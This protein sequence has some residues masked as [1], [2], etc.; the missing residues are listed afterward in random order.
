MYYAN[1]AAEK[2]LGKLELRNQ[3]ARKAYE[4]QEIANAALTVKSTIPFNMFKDPILLDALGLKD[5]YLEADLERAI[6]AGLESFILEFGHGMSFVAR[7]KRMTMDGADHYLDLLFYHRDLKRLV[8]V[9]LKIGAFIPRDEGQ[10]RFYLKWLNRY[11][12]REGENEPIGLILCTRADR[13]QVELMDLDSSGIAVAEY[14]TNLP[15][16]A[17]LEEKIRAILHEARERL[18]RR[19][20]LPAG[21]SQKQI[22][23]FYETDE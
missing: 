14:W 5:N 23:W 1:D 15:P 20:S 6:V 16:K 11:E 12:R 2:H 3:I 21:K 4:R 17:L 22:N 13:S 19:K 10:M 9:E 18:Q 8:A 7:Q